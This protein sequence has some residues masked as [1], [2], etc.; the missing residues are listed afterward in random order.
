M[1]RR[2]TAKAH[3]GSLLES[4]KYG[5][6]SFSSPGSGHRVGQL[7]RA[8][9]PTGEQT[10]QQCSA[11]PGI[12]QSRASAGQAGQDGC[13][14]TGDKGKGGLDRRGIRTT[15]TG[16]PGDAGRRRNRVHPAFVRACTRQAAFG[17]G[18]CL[19]S[20]RTRFLIKHGFFRQTDSPRRCR[21][22]NGWAGSYQ[23]RKI[24]AIS[25]TS[26]S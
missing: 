8:T 16:D 22:A 20:S 3:P 18:P 15:Q 5:R 12:M 11:G 26:R 19:D 4:R 24:P 21:G 13:A 7:G 14:R 25:L 9:A 23:F 2:K 1:G 17:G 10:M 6:N